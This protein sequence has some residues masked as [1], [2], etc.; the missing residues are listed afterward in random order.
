MLKY[1][2]SLRTFWR[3]VRRCKDSFLTPASAFFDKI[4]VSQDV[5]TI[6]SLVCGVAAACGL[7]VSKEVFFVLILLYF[8]FDNL[9]GSLARFRGVESFWFDHITDRVVVISV[10]IS[11][12]LNSPVLTIFHIA[13]PL[14]YAFSHIVHL[15][16]RKETLILY[17]AFVYYVLVMF[18]FHL[19][20]LF[21][22]VYV[23][24][25]IILLSLSYLFL[26]KKR[27]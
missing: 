3:G 6:M 12:A 7:F 14:M 26:L 8:V 17:W 16:N 18:D 1:I 25:N 5:L 4:G 2:S 19:A 23:S 27:S 9:D 22:F 20:T 24:V 13:L 21:G 15:F 10:F 11:V